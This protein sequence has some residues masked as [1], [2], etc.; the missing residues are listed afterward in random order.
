MVSLGA[1]ET[2]LGD[3]PHYSNNGRKPTV[4]GVV[5]N[6]LHLCCPV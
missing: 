6:V 3:S 4:L 5:L 1:Q 2:C